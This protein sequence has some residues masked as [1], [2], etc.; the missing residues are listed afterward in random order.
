M[1]WTE[2]RDHE[3]QFSSDNEAPFDPRVKVAAGR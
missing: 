3:R 2:G 1:G